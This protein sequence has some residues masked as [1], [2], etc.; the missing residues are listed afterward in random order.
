MSGNTA[1]TLETKVFRLE[2][3]GKALD[4]KNSLLSFSAPANNPTQLWSSCTGV[5][6]QWIVNRATGAYLVVDS[7]TVSVKIELPYEWNIQ[8][9]GSSV[10]LKAASQKIY[11][12]SSQQKPAVSPQEDADSLFTI[13]YVTQPVLSVGSEDY[14]KSPEHTC[15][16]NHVFNAVNA[17]NAVIHILEHPDSTQPVE[18]MVV[19]FRDH[20]KLFKARGDEATQNL[21]LARQTV[22]SWFTVIGAKMDA[23]AKNKGTIESLIRNEDPG[24]KAA[25]NNW[26]NSVLRTPRPRLT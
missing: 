21:E 5:N 13:T 14:V 16:T 6:G 4:A 7:N 10:R 25:E 17:L 2:H 20:I 26:R 23:E 15:V 8:D 12:Q 18:S 1:P 11:L 22:A 19:L 9:G 3:S 24:L